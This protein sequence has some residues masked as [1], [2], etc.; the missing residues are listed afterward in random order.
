MID[1]VDDIAEFYEEDPQREELWRKRFN[2]CE[3]GDSSSQP[4]SVVSASWAT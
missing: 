1:H 4:S 2:D 3:G